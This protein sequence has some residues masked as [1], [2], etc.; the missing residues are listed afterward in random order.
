MASSGLVKRSVLVLIRLLVP[1]V[2]L[3]AAYIGAG[4]AHGVGITALD[5][6]A[7]AEPWWLVPG[8]WLTF[9]HLAIMLAFFVSML[10]NRILGPA[11]A[12]AQVVTV[13][14][15]GAAL[16]IWFDHTTG[17]ASVNFLPAPRV[18]WA[19]IA[20]LALAHIV[21]IVVYELMLGIPWWRAPLLAGLAAAIA[22]PLVY[23]PIAKLGGEPWLA[24]AVL[25]AGL[26]GAVAVA[27]VAIFAVLRPI[28]RPRAG[29]GGH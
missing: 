15:I 18:R 2:G 4:F 27:L 7:P 22:L 25:D 28:T 16:W 21:N 20:A 26:K 6:I 19:F 3:V 9:G 11:Y 1:V 14:S 13:W 24:R 17:G 10:T 8:Y 12:L 23:W 5:H 29:L